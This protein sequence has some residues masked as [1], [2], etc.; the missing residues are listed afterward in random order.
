MAASDTPES[1]RLRTAAIVLGIIGILAL[2]AAIV[3]FVVPANHLPNIPGV[4][5]LANATRHHT[6]RAVAGLILAVLCLGGAAWA[7][8]RSRQ[9]MY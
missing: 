4:G 9:L 8:F 1:R 3:Y 7:W 5:H 6:K 2:I